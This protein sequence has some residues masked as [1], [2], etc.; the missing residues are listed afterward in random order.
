[1]LFIGAAMKLFLLLWWGACS[2]PPQIN[3]TAI[4]IA[5]SSSSAIMAEE[6]ESA[7]VLLLDTAPG[8]SGGEDDLKLVV[9]A[10]TPKA[11]G[12]AAAA[13]GPSVTETTED[14]PYTEATLAAFALDMIAIHGLDKGTFVKEL[15]RQNKGK[16]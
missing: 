14:T 3:S 11:K 1:M 12:K 9:A 8:D 7:V 16:A 2:T 10:D 5:T 4:A 13:D 15:T 6:S